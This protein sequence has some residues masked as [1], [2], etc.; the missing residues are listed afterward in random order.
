VRLPPAE[1]R[2]PRPNVVARSTR[3]ARAASRRGDF[4]LAGR[5]PR[6]SPR[7]TIP[8]TGQ[9]E[10]RAARAPLFASAARNY[11]FVSGRWRRRPINIARARVY[12]VPL[13]KH[14]IIIRIIIL[15]QTN[16][17]VNVSRTQQFNPSLLLKTVFMQKNVSARR[18]RNLYHTRYP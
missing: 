15:S 11:V 18:A 10:H 14:S 4:P 17:V 12:D 5:A 13:S 2:G 8:A 6:P 1:L 3:G 7:P 9:D 16:K